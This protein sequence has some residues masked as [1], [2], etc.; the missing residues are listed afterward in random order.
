MSISSVDNIESSLPDENEKVK[1]TI[2]VPHIILNTKE[3]QCSMLDD[4]VAAGVLPVIDEVCTMIM[5][6]LGRGVCTLQTDCIRWDST[7]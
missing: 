4:A 6:V 2:G 7:I 3:V 5:Y 1:E